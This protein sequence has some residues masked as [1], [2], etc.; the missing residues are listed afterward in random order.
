MDSQRHILG[1]S[2]NWLADRL[3]PATT[4]GPQRRCYLWASNMSQKRKMQVEAL[5]AY[6]CTFGSRECRNAGR[7]DSGVRLLERGEVVL[8]RTLVRETLT[9]G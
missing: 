2:G 5:L 6:C 3:R 1:T 4:L 8:V 9:V 7:G